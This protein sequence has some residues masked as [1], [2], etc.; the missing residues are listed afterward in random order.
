[1][2]GGDVLKKRKGDTKM[3][4]QRMGDKGWGEERNKNI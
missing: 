2:K 1:M 3:G 4:K